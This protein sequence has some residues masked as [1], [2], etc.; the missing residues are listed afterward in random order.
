[1]A[2][3]RKRGGYFQLVE[4]Y[5]DGGKVRQRFIAALGKNATP[6]KALAAYQA[7]I[8]ESHVQTTHKTCRTERLARRRE[9]LVQRASAL[10]VYLAC[11]G[12]HDKQTTYGA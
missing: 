4:T 2:F 1:M 8:S 12:K 7:E 3:I 9:R 10:E 6:E 5:R 11:S